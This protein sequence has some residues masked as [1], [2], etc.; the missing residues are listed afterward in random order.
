MA[1]MNTIFNILRFN[2]KIDIE[3]LG[4]S[5]SQ[6]QTSWGPNIPISLIQRGTT[7]QNKQTKITIFTI[8]NVLE[9]KCNH[10]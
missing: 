9:N 10:S 7:H 4:T 2:L 1:V 8:T 6:L 3:A 5:L